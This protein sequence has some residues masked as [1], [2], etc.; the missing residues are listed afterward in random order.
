MWKLRNVHVVQTFSSIN[1]GYAYEFVWA[2]AVFGYLHC[3]FLY[4]IFSL[5]RSR[6]P[7]LFC[8]SWLEKFLIN[9]PILGPLPDQM[10]ES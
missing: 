1:I 2:R 4:L 10:F 8:Q 5:S 9:G 6:S 3:C 7:L